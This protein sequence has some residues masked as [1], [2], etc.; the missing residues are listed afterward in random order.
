MPLMPHDRVKFSSGGAPE[1]RSGR[2]SAEDGV[3]R[4]RPV[5]TVSGAVDA[6]ATGGAAN[7]VSTP[8]AII[9]AIYKLIFF[10]KYIPLF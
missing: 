7:G 4:Y 5:G 3:C 10:F 6:S 1:I 9:K 8:K 2:L